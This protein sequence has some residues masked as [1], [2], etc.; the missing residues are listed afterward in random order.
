MFSEIEDENQD[1]QRPG[2]TDRLSWKEKV[3]EWNPTNADVF[4]ESTSDFVSNVENG[5]DDEDYSITELSEARKFLF[6]SRAY[7]WLIE[8][9]RAEFVLTD[10]KGTALNE[11]RYELLRGLA[12]YPRRSGYNLLTPV[13][14]FQIVWSP[15]SF[16]SR[17][18]PHTSAPALGEIIVLN[19]AQVDAQASTCAQYIQQT[20]TAT[21][22]EILR[23]LERVVARGVKGEAYER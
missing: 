21:G 8:K 20:W 18:F 14:E 22:V 3:F 5:V 6:E 9:L 23:L 11:I 17:Q 2:D 10:R 16:L 19:G 1:I 7:Q 12:V 13:A 15:I 4:E